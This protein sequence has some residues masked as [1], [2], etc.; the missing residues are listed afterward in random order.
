[1]LLIFCSSSTECETVCSQLVIVFGKNHPIS[2]SALSHSQT[3]RQ[4]WTSSPNQ[5]PTHIAGVNY[6]SVV[7]VSPL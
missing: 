1:M 6:T 7:D 4:T 3:D 5:K 2:L